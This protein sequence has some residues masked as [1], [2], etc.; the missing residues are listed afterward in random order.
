MLRQIPQSRLGGE[1][2]QRREPDDIRG[3]RHR[4]PGEVADLRPGRVGDDPVDRSVPVEKVA[5]HAQ[6]APMCL[7]RRV[8]LIEER[9]GSACGIEHSPADQLPK[10]GKKGRCQIGRG[11]HQIARGGIGRRC[12]P[13][14]TT[15]DGLAK[16]FA[17]AKHPERAEQGRDAAGERALERDNGWARTSHPRRQPRLGEPLDPA[18]GGQRGSGRILSLTP[19]PT[20]PKQRQDCR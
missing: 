20:Q 2:H 4:M 18:Q 8:E 7:Q 6:L 15:G 1:V 11:H 10:M 19:S 17:D 14:R 3:E 16:G 12:E 13:A 5:P 9:A